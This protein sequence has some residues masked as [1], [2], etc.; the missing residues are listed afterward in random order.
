MK[1]QHALAVLA[2][3][4]PLAGACE[5]A[6]APSLGNKNTNWLV[7]C[8]TSVECGDAAQC[9]CGVCT[10]P[11]AA[12]ADCSESSGTCT[13]NLATTLQ[14]GGSAESA[15]CLKSC[16]EAA[17]CNDSEACVQGS[18]VARVKDLC[19]EHADAVLCAELEEAVPAGWT[20]GSS[21]GSAIS[22][23]SELRFS[24]AASLLARTAG[25]GGRSRILREIPM[26]TSGVLYLRA[27]AYMNPGAVVDDV[28]SIVVGDANT[29]DFG[30]KFL[31]SAGK[32]QVATAA[33]DV[34]GSVS[35]PFGRWY[36]VRLE[37]SIGDAGSVKAY[38]DDDVLA[39][40]TGVDTLP[41]TGVHN[42][43]VGIDFAGQAESG[44]LYLDD[45]LV[46]TQPVDCAR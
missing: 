44:E 46:D 19:K 6:S 25:A 37:L 41:A 34:A 39:D 15:V 18:C 27:W 33:A 21:A 40:Q 45:V 5:S 31:Y 28:H 2:V 20:D 24:G 42:I 23:S 11:C 10:I 43:S 38:I 4:L 1:I 30:T 35:P 26:M 29:A 13:E 14:C 7:S 16:A 17:D 3:L 32:L 9:T 22:A 36:C 8:S 12:S